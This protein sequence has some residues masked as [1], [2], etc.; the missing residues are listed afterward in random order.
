MSQGAN[1]VDLHT[2]SYGS[3][4]GGLT[5][6][7]YRQML[8]SGGLDWVAITDH[9]TIDAALEIRQ[10]LGE[11]GERIIVGE[12]V[13]TSE[14]ELIGLFLAQTVKPGQSLRVSAEDILGQGGV[15]Y[16]PH[17]FETVRSGVTPEA[18]ATLEGLPY[19]V[20]THNGR[21]YVG[22]K[23]AQARAWAEEHGVAQAASSDAHGP[24]GW[25][26]TYTLMSSAPAPGLDWARAL[27]HATLKRGRVG[28]GVVYPK[29]HRLRKLFRTKT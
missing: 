11:V 8:S 1:A 18:L 29:Y 6:G 3:P 22:N 13:M 19:I 26:K 16:V 14:G 2:H 28:L 24:L 5:V 4:D 7:D 27:K 23:G 17:P 15:L 10:A 12:E 25:G 20:E 21:A 9:N